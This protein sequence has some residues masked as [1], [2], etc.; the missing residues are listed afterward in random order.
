MKVKVN[1]E[2]MGDDTKYQFASYSFHSKAIKGLD[3]CIKKTLI[4]TCSEDKT[5]RIW[6][7]DTKKLD[8]VETYQEQA[9]SIAFHPS[10][11]HVVVGFSDR[12]RMMNVFK[13]SLK[14]YK[15]I[16]IKS[17]IELKF[18]NGGHL[19]AAAN[20]NSICVY[21]FYT[22]ENRSDMVFKNHKGRVKTIS[23]F[24]D[25]TGFVSAGLDGMIYIWDLK[26]SNNPEFQFK[27]KGTVFQCVEK[28]QDAEKRVFAVGTDK[29]LREISY[30]LQTSDKGGPGGAGSVIQTMAGSQGKTTELNANEI[31]R[32]ESNVQFAQVICLKDAR[33]L[34]VGTSDTDRPSSIILFRLDNLERL[35][36]VQAHSQPITR[37]I[38]NYE[39]TCLFTGSQDGSLGMW[40]I[41]QKQKNKEGLQSL[42]PSKEI[43]C[44]RAELQALLSSIDNYNEMNEQLKKD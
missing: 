2:R 3:I 33:G 34:I 11:F 42:V 32:F 38:V 22:G 5:V 10:G 7:Y 43:L 25:D 20:T 44:E 40:D 15:E 29:T 1:L 4:A 28:S 30:K 21:N 37:M 41:N 19:F 14:G 36:E 8:I 16:H 18:A 13:E 31:R 9:H 23:W 12:V 17:C 39:N 35:F 27:N 24:E 26:N 6:N